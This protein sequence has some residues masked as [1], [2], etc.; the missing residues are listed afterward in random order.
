M[1]ICSKISSVTLRFLE[2]AFA[3]IIA[4]LL[5]RFLHWFTVASVFANS[6]VVYTEVIA[7]ISI[8]VSI[9][10]M[11]PLK[12]SFYC[13]AFDFVLFICWMVAFGLLE[14]VSN[15]LKNPEYIS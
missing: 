9:I 2:L 14:N 10:L 6:R 11:P 5:G 4:G 15:F 8:L 7:G 12:Y 1:G 13:F 3:S